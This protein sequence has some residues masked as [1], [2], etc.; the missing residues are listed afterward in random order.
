MGKVILK[1]DAFVRLPETETV[2]ELLFEAGEE[3]V[4]KIHLILPKN[5]YVDEECAFST[6]KAINSL[7]ET[8]PSIN[9]LIICDLGILHGGHYDY[10]KELDC[11]KFFYKNYRRI[12]Q[13]EKVFFQKNS[14]FFH[15]RY[16]N[17][18]SFSRDD[19]SLSHCKNID[20]KIS[21]FI[22]DIK[23][24]NLSSFE[25]IMAT[26]IL[27]SRFIDSS[28]EDN[29]KNIYSSVFNILS[30]GDDGYQIHCVGYT[31]LFCRMLDKMDINAIPLFVFNNE[32]GFAHSAALVDVCDES[33]EINGSFICDVRGESDFRQSLEEG[34]LT[35]LSNTDNYYGED[36]L[37]YFCLNCDDYESITTLDKFNTPILYTAKELGKVDEKNLISKERIPLEKIGKALI[38]TSIFRFGVD[39][40][41]FKNDNGNNTIRDD[42]LDTF[43]NLIYS[44]NKADY[45]NYVYNNEL[46]HMFTDTKTDSVKVANDVKKP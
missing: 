14:G 32:K 1:E 46:E 34:F 24:S 19:F 45:F 7:L 18:M 3:N 27:C 13:P 39:V 21:L 30:D 43:N 38:E 12:E 20:D 16:D 5:F 42:F 36:R 17:A 37:R 28:T 41:T 25:K 10:K 35:H 9:K 29:E 33:Y 2:D 15:S 31:D 8:V 11:E 23:D 26:Y 44:R 22:N 4:D 6:Y 40:E